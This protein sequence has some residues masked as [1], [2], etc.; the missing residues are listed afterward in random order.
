MS[1]KIVFVQGSPRK[2]GNT[3][4]MAAMAMDAARSRKAVVTEIDATALEF[5]HP[6]CLGCQKC[7]QSEEFACTIGDGVAAAVAILPANDVIVMATPLYW[8]SFSAQIKIFIDRMYS[9]SKFTADGELQSLL[10]GKTLALLATAAGPLEDNL[11]LLER[12]WK[13][14]AEMLDCR[15]VS[16]L[17][18]FAPWQAGELAR[19]PEAAARAKAFGERLAAPE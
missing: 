16:C 14:P 13:H 8:W 2:N 6:G 15:F 3:R 19:S 17:F 18:P 9:L 5:K 10:R 1:Q 12:Q 11:E 4:A 7:Q